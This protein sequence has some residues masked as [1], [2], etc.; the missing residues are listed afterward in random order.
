[1]DRIRGLKTPV[2]SVPI[3]NRKNFSEAD[4]MIDFNRHISVDVYP[5][6]MLCRDA[7]DEKVKLWGSEIPLKILNQYNPSC[8]RPGL[9]QR[10]FA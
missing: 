1:M 6:A 3:K 10:L 7:F 8:Q 5:C 2:N 4:L 9:L